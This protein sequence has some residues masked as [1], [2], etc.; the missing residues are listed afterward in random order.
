M[1]VIV[2]N[3]NEYIVSKELFESIVINNPE[4]LFETDMGELIASRL[5]D[6]Y[7]S[8]LNAKQLKTLRKVVT[9]AA[10]S[11]IDDFKQIEKMVEKQLNNTSSKDKV[12]DQIISQQLDRNQNMSGDI[13]PSTLKVRE[14]KTLAKEKAK[15]QYLGNNQQLIKQEQPK[16]SEKT[17]T[18]QDK[19]TLGETDL[20][21]LIKKGF[22]NNRINLEK[23]I[24][25]K[26]ISMFSKE[27]LISQIETVKKDNNPQQKV[28]EIIKDWLGTNLEMLKNDNPKLYDAFMSEGNIDS[29]K[30]PKEGIAAETEEMTQYFINMLKANKSN[31]LVQ[32]NMLLKRI[33]HDIQRAGGIK[34]ITY[35]INS[36]TADDDGTIKRYFYG[37]LE[38]VNNEKT[39]LVKK[40][41][42]SHDKIDKR[43]STAKINK[44]IEN[45]SYSISYGTDK[46]I[47]DSTILGAI[48]MDE[49]LK[50]KYYMY[51]S[52][53]PRALN[54]TE[55]GMVLINKQTDQVELILLVKPILKYAKPIVSQAL[56]SLKR[57]N[58]MKV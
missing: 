9:Q 38:F 3:G 57:F 21:S 51:Q 2:R 6:K 13:Q 31:S 1:K 54:V 26:V 16:K 28:D 46:N 43:F 5:K 25:Q 34:N 45:I 36:N 56:G 15:Q 7:N 22:K 10:E 23:Q 32:P 35:F 14:K 8:P 29:Y 11:G 48:R 17:N 37:A 50:S 42:K 33:E 20:Y 47:T 52:T 4:I 55:Y 53:T 49:T 19:E 30:E 24:T 18:N 12:N 39:N 44:A 58:T 40:Y 41:L 27:E